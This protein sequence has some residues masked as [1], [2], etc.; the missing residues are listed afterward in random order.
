MAVGW[1]HTVGRGIG[2]AAALAGWA[3]GD[4]GRPTSGA[5]STTATSTVDS[6]TTDTGALETGTTGTGATGTGTTGEDTTAGEP[7]LP[8]PGASFY[9]FIGERVTLDGSASTGAVQYQWNFDDGTPAAA[10]S[11]RPT[12]STTYPTPGRYHP[13]LTVF[14]ADGQQLAAS[15]TVTVTQVPSH[16]PRH[17]STVVRLADDVRVAV[18]SPDSDE[19]TVV[20]PTDDDRF[21]VQ[22]RLPTGDH[23]RTA[24]ALPDG[25][26]AVACQDDDTVWLVDPDGADG[27]A[28][29][30]P[31]GSRPY[32]V[33]ADGDQVFVSLQ[34]RGELARIDAGRA[35]P[36]V[37]QTWPVVS[38]AR[39]VAVLP[40]G[41][42]AVTRWRSAD[43]VAQI[44]VLDPATGITQPVSLQF[45]DTPSADTVSGGIPSYL[46]QV[47]VSPIGDQAAVPSLQANFTQGAYLDG[48][49]LTFE[50]TVR[51]VV[52]VLEFS[53]AQPAVTIVENFDRRNQFDNRGFM[54]AGTFSSRGDYLFLAAR[55][56][57]AV[58]RIDTFNDAQAGTLVDVGYAPAGLVLSADDRLLFVDAFASRT[59]AVYDVSDFSVLPQPLAELPIPTV[60]P[61]SPQDMRGQQL[62]GDAFDPRL[63]RDSYIACAHCHLDGE[64]DHR[65]WDFTDRGEGLR[66]TITLRG[67]GGLGHGPLHWTANF[68]EV[69]DFENDIRN[70]FDGHGLL[71]DAD[72]NAGT[73]NQT[74]GDP[75]AGLSEDLDAL[76]A[77]VSSL[78]GG[79]R[80]PARLPDGSLDPAAVA[81]Q[82]LF[83]SPALGCTT[84]HAGPNTTDSAFM[85]PGVPILH[86]VGTLTEASG[87]R[88]GQPLTGLDTPTLRGIWN[89][90]PY[91]HD[92]SAISLTAV[93]TTANP[94]D[95]HGIT[96]MLTNEQIQQVVA[97]LRST[98]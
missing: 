21:V 79:M 91:L 63:A 48:N 37:V 84:C 65:T 76:A 61:L 86:D 41:R 77:Y 67:R 59:L 34:A 4:D 93:L 98:E 89:T 90:A 64:A 45:D 87:Q 73:T 26:V 36:D 95:L 40:D 58:E 27:I 16:V 9:A 74:L 13:V 78:V 60:E 54:A 57:R 46:D 38:D 19:L 14:G 55:G 7:L 20:A 43:D 53:G 96:S 31:H 52:S 75:K 71:D 22:T 39:G 92:G 28:V 11:A 42:I 32:G 15:L 18:V 17:D 70:A 81:G 10:P 25:R 72:W 3:C 69:Q 68:D 94:D 62:F 51:G 5:S 35:I 80:S 23:P 97:Y 44:V 66:N 30:L 1:V 47:L 50:T 2:M 85:A 12:A 29:A 88:L 49:P 24:T 6:T 82:I 33:V 56:S 83:E 8:I